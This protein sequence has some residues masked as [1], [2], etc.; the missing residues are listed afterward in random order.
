MH[1]TIKHNFNGDF[2]KRKIA[3]LILMLF[4][5]SITLVACGNT[6]AT[7]V[8]ARW[9]EETHVFNIMLADFISANSNNLKTY[10][11]K[12]EP[13]N[14]GSYAKDVAFSTEF[15][16]WDEIRPLDVAGTYVLNI[17]PSGDNSSYCEVTTSQVMYVK[18]SLQSETTSGVDFEKY[19]ELESAKVTDP[20]EYTAKGLT[21]ED[22][23]VILKSTTETYVQFENTTSQKPLKS[24]TTVKGFY[25]GNK[26]QN[27]TDYSIATEYDYGAKK[28]VAKITLNGEKSEYT[29]FARN[30][31]GTFIDSNQ[32]LTYLR[33]LD[34]TS[35]SFQDNPSINV[36][37][38]YNQSLQSAGFALNYGRGIVLTDATKG[39]IATKLGFVSVSIGNNPFMTQANLPDNLT[40]N[41]EQLDARNSINNKAEPLF[42]T[43]RFRVGYFAYEID[44]ASP[45]NKIN[46]EPKNWNDIWTALTPAP[47]TEEK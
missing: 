26:N 36:F 29:G 47:K 45:L 46:G 16:N 35:N 27:V 2:M 30:S 42:T 10:N 43:V 15:H 21:L 4:A 9:E 31:A 24:S 3:L 20:A 1:F 12:A 22:G 17:K 34:K 19:P 7:A 11:D 23:T 8:R 41:D 44:Y 38:P 25:V 32:L 14:S 13:V 5:V 18:Y 33:S 40:L 6:D 37:N 39:S 28:P